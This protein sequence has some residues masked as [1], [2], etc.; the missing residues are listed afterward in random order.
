MGLLTDFFSYLETSITL[1]MTPF[2]RKI[3]DKMPDNNQILM[4]ERF[5]KI[6]LGSF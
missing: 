5:I 3:C 2:F 6:Q 1:Q 4:H